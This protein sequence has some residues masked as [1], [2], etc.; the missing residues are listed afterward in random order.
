LQSC[1]KLGLTDGPHVLSL[2]RRRCRTCA[3]PGRR[4]PGSPL[5][6]RRPDRCAT[7]HRARGPAHARHRARQTTDLPDLVALILA[8]GLVIWPV[9]TSRLAGRTGT[10][11]N[12]PS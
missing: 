6:G 4:R 8:Y 12:R 2:V 7:S 9:D 11:V 10:R 5:P 3:R 1:R